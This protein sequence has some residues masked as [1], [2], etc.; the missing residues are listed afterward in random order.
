MREEIQIQAKRKSNN[1]MN[2][3]IEILT[4]KYKKEIQALMIFYQK[5]IINKILILLKKKTIMKKQLVQY[6]IRNRAI[7]QKNIGK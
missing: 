6:L 7:L 4:Q 3:P 5:Q 2:N 1:K